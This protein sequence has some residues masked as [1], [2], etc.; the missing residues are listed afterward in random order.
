[1][2]PVPGSPGCVPWWCLVMKIMHQAGLGLSPT[3]PL[4]MCT[5][6]VHLENL[7][8]LTRKKNRNKNNSSALSQGPIKTMDAGSLGRSVVERLPSAQ[9]MILEFQDRVPQGACFSFCLCLC[10]SLGVSHE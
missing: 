1:M 3:P 6:A 2:Y 7:S 4:S 10:L 9:G 8:V 5:R